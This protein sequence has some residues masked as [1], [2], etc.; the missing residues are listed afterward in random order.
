MTE[1]ETARATMTAYLD[2]LTARGAYEQFFAPDASLKLMGTDQEAHGRD[3]VAGMIRYLHEQAFDA[4]PQVNSLLVDG[5]RAALEADFVGRHVSEFA[6][7][8]ATGKDIRVP[9]SVVYDLQGDQIIA[10]RIY[11]ALDEILRQLEA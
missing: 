3:Q 5:E 8:P 11:L 9:Y 7:K 1:V 2:A 4:H 6:G 10:L